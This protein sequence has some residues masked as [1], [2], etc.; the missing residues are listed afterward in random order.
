MFKNTP[1]TDYTIEDI[2]VLILLN[3]ALT[4]LISV[5]KLD[6]TPEIELVKKVSGSNKYPIKLDMLLWIQY[7]KLLSTSDANGIYIGLHLYTDQFA[8]IS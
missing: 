7:T 2:K 1:K 5:K 8:C 4:E 3:I 6:K